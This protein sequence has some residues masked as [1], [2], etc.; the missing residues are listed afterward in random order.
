MAEQRHTSQQYQIGAFKETEEES[1]MAEAEPKIFENK[2][3]NNILQ[4]FEGHKQCK[5]SYF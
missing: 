3:V 4:D 2:S 1:I 5:E